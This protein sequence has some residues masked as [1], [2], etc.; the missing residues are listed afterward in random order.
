[1]KTT[2]LKDTFEI[3]V[4]AKHFK[5][6]YYLDSPICKAIN[7]K[8]SNNVWLG[9]ST[10]TIFDLPQNRIYN[11]DMFINGEKINYLTNDIYYNLLLEHNPQLF[12]NDT[13]S[14]YREL[15]KY[16]HLPYFSILKK[17]AKQKKK[18]GTFKIKF[19]EIT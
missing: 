12:S 5:D 3:N 8:I 4:S 1:M 19:N 15:K 14:G 6:L 2:E 16:K 18:V 9:I 17:L 10:L 7:E 11:F 13:V